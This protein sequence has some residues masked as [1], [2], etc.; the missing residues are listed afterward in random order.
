[1]GAKKRCE[2][3]KPFAAPRDKAVLAPK[4]LFEERAV[5]AASR[6]IC[7]LRVFR[8]EGAPC[9]GTV[10][11]FR[12]NIMHG[13]GNAQH[14]AKRDQIRADV[15]C[16]PCAVVCAPVCHYAVNIAESAVP[17]RRGANQVVGQ[18]K[19]VRLSRTE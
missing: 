12:G 1:M 3:Q 16:G 15:A 2:K 6:I 5:L 17:V 11:L 8:A 13:N 19:S 7:S 4:F 9:M 14:R 10:D 18:Q